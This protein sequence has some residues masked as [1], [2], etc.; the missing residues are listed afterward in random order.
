MGDIISSSTSGGSSSGMGNH[1]NT[2]ASRR[3]IG[4]QSGE[5]Y[6]FLSSTRVIQ[7]EL[8]GLFSENVAAKIWKVAAT[9]LEQQV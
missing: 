3:H 2:I 8:E 9:V 1:D 7:K 5:D 6:E 4:A